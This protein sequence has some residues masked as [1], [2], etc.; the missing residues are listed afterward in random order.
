MGIRRIRLCRGCGRKFTPKKQKAAEP[1]NQAAEEQTEPSA[2]L[3]EDVDV[4]SETEAPGENDTPA[5]PAEALA[6][7][8]PPPD[9]QWT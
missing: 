5:E 2:A 3:Q 6:L 4:P 9:Q 8:F 7:V 1:L